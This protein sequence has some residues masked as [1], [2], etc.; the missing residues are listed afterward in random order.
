MMSVK[1]IGV[2]IIYTIG[3]LMTLIMLYLFLSRSDYVP[4]PDSMLPASLWELSTEWL[5]LGALP[6]AIASRLLD[7]TIFSQESGRDKKSRLLLYL[8]AI[9]CTCFFLYWA[10]VLAIG[11]FNTMIHI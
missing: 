4:H 1:K 8:P 2:M 7:R 10:L 9:L 6:M 5:A 3:V 11:F